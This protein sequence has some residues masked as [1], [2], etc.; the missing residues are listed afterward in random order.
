MFPANT[1]RSSVPPNFGIR[2]GTAFVLVAAMEIKPASP[3][4][5]LWAAPA[6]LLAAMVIAWAAE[7]AQYFIAQG[8]ALAILAWLQTMPEFAVEAVLAWRQQSHL[9][10]ANLTGSLRLLTGLGWPMIYAVAAW[11]HRHKYGRPLKSIRLEN[12]HA[13]EVLALLAPVLF[14]VVIWFKGA[15]TVIDAVILVVIYAAY[16][17]MLAKM[18]PQEHEGIDDLDRVP[19]TVVRMP[20]LWRTISIVALFACGG[21]L[22]YYAA[23]PFLG[24]LFAIS[25]LVGVPEFVFV[26]WVAPFVSEFPEK[27]S[28]FHWARTIERAPMALMNM[29]SS[30]INQWTLLAAMLPILYSISR[31]S[32]SPIVFDRQQELEILLTI[33]QSLVG[34]IFLINLEMDWKEAAALFGLWF[35]QFILSPIKPDETLVGILAHYSHSVVA[36][37]YFIWFGVAVVGMVRRRETPAA[38]TEFRNLWRQYVARA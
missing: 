2:A 33:G 27:V 24:S 15:L 29:V 18:P 32:M 7:S 21:A 16:V 37:A 3:E 34:M 12:E 25:A 20:A 36:A 10:I 28:A 23:E 22:I 1:P 31:G 8:F 14:W 17:W 9:L 6:I 19:R 30:N 35:T 26:Q 5:A 13:I 4:T 11:S 38:F